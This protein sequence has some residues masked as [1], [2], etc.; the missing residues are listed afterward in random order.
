MAELLLILALIAGAMLLILAE[1]CTPAFGM[2][3]VAAMVCLGAV[4]YRCFLI[5]PVLGI[6]ALVA[7][8]I[9]VP[10]YLRYL[11]RLFPKTPLGKRLMLRKLQ[12]DKGT[13]V[14]EAVEHESLIGSEGVATTTL[15]PSGTVI[16]D[17]KRRVATAETG[18]IPEHTR[19][20]VVRSSGM[21][22]VVRAIDEPTGEQ[23]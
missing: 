15:R 13:G 11:I 12:I 18:F 5:S 4:V 9:G 22:L 23:D 21:N 14:P 20:K 3:A 19:V 8:L 10:V 17:G 7:V 16:L 6:V 2:L 1:I